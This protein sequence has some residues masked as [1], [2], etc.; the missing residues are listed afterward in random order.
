MAERGS[1]KHGPELDD[2]MKHETEGM[3]DGTQP[4][5]VEEFRQTEGMPD[6]TDSEEVEDAAGMTGAEVD[7]ELPWDENPGSGG[8]GS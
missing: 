5:H 8:Q 7:D 2:E 4:D 6:D 1:T 3:I